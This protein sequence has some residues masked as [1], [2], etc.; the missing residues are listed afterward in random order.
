MLCGEPTTKVSSCSGTKDIATPLPSRTTPRAVLLEA[1]PGWVMPWRLPN[2][3]PVSRNASS[4]AQTD[5]QHFFRTLS[6][7]K[8]HAGVALRTF[9]NT[10]G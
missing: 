6:K 5:V 3:P 8:H 2:Q 7:R 4:I 10:R 1:G 9:E